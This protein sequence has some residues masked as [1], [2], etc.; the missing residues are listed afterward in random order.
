MVNFDE[1]T[2]TYTNENGKNLTSVTQLLKLAGLTPDYSTVDQEVLTRKAERGTLIHKEI[3]NFIKDGS[4]GFT[5]E[6]NEFIKYITDN[7]IT[8]IY[9]ELIVY[10]DDIAGCIDMVA[11][12]KEGKTH[13]VD[14]KTTYTIHKET[15]SWQ[16]SIYKYLFEKLNPSKNDKL[17]IENIDYLDVYHF[18]KEGKLEVLSLPI[19]DKN[20]VENLKNI[21]NGTYENN[22]DNEFELFTIQSQIDCLKAKL[23]ELETKKNEELVKAV[24][25]LKIAGTNSYKGKVNITI[26]AP[27]KKV[28]VDTKALKKDLPDIYEKYKKETETKESYRVSI[29]KEA[30]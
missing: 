23:E 21:L 5:V 12:D 26:V 19:K 11:V 6:L 17:K 27:V 2:H 16:T 14:F 9:S 4:I 29:G 24:E 20:Q 28:S 30:E 1:K 15:C 8:P 22:I 18:D 10:D 7:S 3:E 25:K 13:L